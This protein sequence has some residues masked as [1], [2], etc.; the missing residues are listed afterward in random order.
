MAAARSPVLRALLSAGFSESVRP[1]VDVASPTSQVENIYED[2][3]RCVWIPA[4][5]SAV[6]S[7]SAATSQKKEVAV[8]VE[9]GAPTFFELRRFMYTDELPALRALHCHPLRLM[10][11][12]DML[13]VIRALLLC[14]C[15][16]VLVCSCARV[17]VCSCARVLVCSCARVPVCSCSRVL[18]CSCARVLVCS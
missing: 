17:L 18:V 15:A 8:V 13:Q 3:S 14:L 5:I 1:A 16:R 4:V 9:G 12:A 10:L 6:D 2:P 7:S 11:A